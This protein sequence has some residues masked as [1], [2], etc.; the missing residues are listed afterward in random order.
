MKTAD[1]LLN[2]LDKH[3]RPLAKG[4][5]PPDCKALMDEVEYNYRVL[6]GYKKDDEI[7][8]SRQIVALTYAMWRLT[9]NRKDI[10]FDLKNQKVK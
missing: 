9:T 1:E 5:V 10:P 4:E 6:A 7:I 2:Q 8:M 3:Y